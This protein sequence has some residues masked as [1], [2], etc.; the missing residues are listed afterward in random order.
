ML[1]KQDNVVI[2][3]ENEQAERAAADNR[4]LAQISLISQPV[5]LPERCH[6]CSSAALD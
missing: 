5:P 6:Q 4:L 3:I 1:Q 2:D